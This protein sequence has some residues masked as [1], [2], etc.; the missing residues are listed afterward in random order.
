MCPELGSHKQISN[1]SRTAF[2]GRDGDFSH[3]TSAGNG[4]APLE[5]PKASPVGFSLFQMTC[6]LLNL[7]ALPGLEP[8]LFALRGRR[9]NQLHHNATERMRNPLRLSKY[10]RPGEEISSLTALQNNTAES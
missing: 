9:V 3:E 8:G 7:V 6:M 4:Q 1:P 10:S 5:I 2:I